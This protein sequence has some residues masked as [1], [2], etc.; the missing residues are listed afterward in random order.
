[1]A[2]FGQTTYTISL[3]ASPSGDGI[4]SGGGTFAAGSTNTATATTNGGYAFMDW[5][6]NNIVVSTATNY[7]F[8]LNSDVTLVANFGP[9]LTVTVSA[10]P[11]LDGTASG[12]GTFASNS[13]VTVT[14]MN[15]NGCAFANWTSDSSVVSTNA[16][17]TFTL[18]SNVDLVANFVPNPLAVQGP[19]FSILGSLPGDQ[20]WPSLSLSPSGGCM[21]WQDNWIDH[22]GGGIGAS[23][24]DTSFNAGHTFRVNKV[25]TGNQFKPQVQLLA[26]DNIIFVWQGSVTVGGKP[27]IYARFAKNP[28]KDAT[29][30]GTNFYTSDIQ[31]NT[32]TA[33]QQVDP[34][35][36]ALPD[37]SA[38]ITWASYGENG[39]GSMWGVYARR[40]TAAGKAIAADNNGSTKQFP[41][42]QYTSYNQRNPAVA[43]LAGGNYVIAWVSEQERSAN[44]V[45]I[46]ARIFSPAGVPVTD[47]IAVNSETN[48][49]DSPAVA[50]LNDGGFTVVW[51]Q[52]DAV[53][54][55]NGWDIWGRAFSA[56]GL[57]EV[58]DFTINT[59]LYGDQYAPK[60]AAGPSGSLVVWTSL[61]QDGSR[62]GV[63]GR[64]LAG[65]TQVSGSE[66]QVNTTWI[67]QQMHPAVAWNGVDH[68]LVVWT[69]F[70]GAG[71]FDLYGQAYV[72]NS[73]P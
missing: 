24:L 47:E 50:P 38:I 42:T 57:P 59:H 48:F 45:D 30:Y 34:A 36:A 73:S 70:V 72:L 68:F 40:L 22:K 2:L 35:V 4:V 55:T 13:T 23:L 58:S 5:T 8:T 9:A 1:M 61:G 6:S 32:Y 12:G 39:S 15:N 44:S 51:A 16:S 18:N 20:V 37:G 63:F 62:E 25:V 14:A 31:A 26:N 41:V 71:G 65:G 21:A 56:S 64:F 54:V 69:S 19:E 46:Y 29:T 49:C 17:Y 7:T 67:S 60:I 11:T 27:Y 10:L 3:S 52:Q 43:T 33:D 66:F 53:V 28:A